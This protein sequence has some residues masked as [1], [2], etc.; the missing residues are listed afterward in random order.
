[1]IV[2]E[3]NLPRTHSFFLFGPRQTGKSTL[4]RTR[5]DPERVMYYDLLRA[6][7]YRRLVAQPET[8]RAEVDAA[9]KSSPDRVNYVVVDEVQRIPELLDEIHGLIEHY[10]GLV[11]VMSGSSARKLK[12]TH[13]NMLGGRAWTLR[14][15]PLTVAE[16]GPDFSLDRALRFGLLPSVYPVRSDEARIETLRSYVDTYVHEEVEQEARTRNIG[17]FVRFLPLVASE[18]GRVINFSNIAREAGISLPTV[19]AYYQILEDTLL[20]FFLFPRLQSV[21]QRV[22]KHPRFYL[23]DPGMVT[24]LQRR[25]SSPLGEADGAAYGRAFEHFL[26]CEIRKIIDYSRAEVDMSFYRTDRGAEVDCILESARGDSVGIEI[27][28]TA[29]PSASHTSGLRSFG[30]VNPGAE[31]I[32]ACRAPRPAQFGRVCAMP[33]R[34]VLRKVRAMCE[35]N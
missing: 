26:V 6:D 21:R 30:A 15:H 18:N 7:E 19:K 32:L 29:T 4:L 12:R 5:L 8:L 25:L 9:M 2:R 33:W 22:V 28:S 24:A 27:K 11:F 10:P 3:I 13:A 17:A 14:L 31:L 20:G 23:F 35:S 34:E 16:M 1:M